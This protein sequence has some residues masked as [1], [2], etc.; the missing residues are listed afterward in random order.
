MP[1]GV[2]GE[3]CAKVER[4]IRL[5][6]DDVADQLPLV[7]AVIAHLARPVDQVHALHP[8]ID[9]EV[10]LTGEIVDVTDQ[11][12]DDLA[13]ASGGIGACGVDDILGEVWV[14]LVG[15]HFD[16]GVMFLKLEAMRGISR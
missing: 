16:N 8:L 10:D 7:P 9:G 4:H 13:G 6:A 2:D 5:Q 12:A 1:G 11:R 3:Q 15:A 14:K